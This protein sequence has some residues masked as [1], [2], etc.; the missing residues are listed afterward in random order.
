MLRRRA[1]AL[2]GGRDSRRAGRPRRK[3]AAPSLSDRPR[4]ARLAPATAVHGRSR[5]CRT[6][7]PARLRRGAASAGRCV[8]PCRTLPLVTG[9][10]SMPERHRGRRAPSLRSRRRSDERAPTRSWCRRPMPSRC[11][12]ATTASAAS[13]RRPAAGIEPA[14][15][16]LPGIAL[17]IDNPADLAHFSRGSARERA[18][19]R[20]TAGAASAGCGRSSRPRG[21][22]GHAAASRQRFARRRGRAARLVD[23]PRR[24][25]S[26]A[27]RL[28]ARPTAIAAALMR[29]AGHWRRQ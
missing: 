23:A 14:I 15:V 8:L 24:R 22:C 28:S 26:P 13:R 2:A 3:R 7:I 29:V 21:G 1:A 9:R 18:V 5:R 16:D 4:G 25:R 12:S 6:A 10:A 19:A 20:A 27:R 11:A 17:D